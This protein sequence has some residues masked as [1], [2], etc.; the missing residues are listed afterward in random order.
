ML[1]SPLGAKISL[2][3]RDIYKWYGRIV[4]TCVVGEVQ[5]PSPGCAASLHPTAR[6][7]QLNDVPSQ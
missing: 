2:M 3:E 7:L 1:H 5:A 6:A 4:R